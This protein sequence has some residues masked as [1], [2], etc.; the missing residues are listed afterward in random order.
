MKMK[1]IIANIKFTHFKN[2]RYYLVPW[3][4]FRVKPKSEA[5]AQQT[6]RLAPRKVICLVIFR[7]F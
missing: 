4:F 6:Q 5:K 1:H 7:Y 3:G 2:I